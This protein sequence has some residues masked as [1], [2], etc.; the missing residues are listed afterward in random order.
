MNLHGIVSGAIGTVNPH[1]PGRLRI[2]TGSSTNPDG[3]RVP[4]YDAPRGVRLQVQPMSWGDLQQVDWL[5]K[6]GE[7]RKIYL[8]GEADAVVRVN[9]KGGDLIEIDSGVNRGTWL[10]VQ[11]LEQFPDWVSCACTLQNGS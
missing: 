2:S 4:T 6:G 3:T 10:I 8:Y 1:I 9:Q 11:T 7:R 5:N